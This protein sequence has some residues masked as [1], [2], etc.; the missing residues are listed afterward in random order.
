MYFKDLPSRFFP[1]Y[2]ADLEKRR[3]K[4]QLT[5]DRCLHYGIKI[6]IFLSEPK[7]FGDTTYSI[8]LED[9]KKGSNLLAPNAVNFIDFAPLQNPA[10]NVWVNPSSGWLK[11]IDLIK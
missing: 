3:N 9:V 11:M 10:C 1:T 4:L 5:I 2:R 8:P 6:Y 7:L